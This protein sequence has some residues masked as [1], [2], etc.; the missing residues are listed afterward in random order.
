M[1]VLAQ[2]MGPDEWEFSNKT[3]RRRSVSGRQLA[4]KGMRLAAEV[5]EPRC[6][7]TES[8][9]IDG[10]NLDPTSADQTAADDAA[11]DIATLTA[12]AKT[13]NIA[14]VTTIVVDGSFW[15]DRGLTV[16][17]VDDWVHIV[18]T[19][20]DLDV[21]PPIPVAE[22]AQLILQGRD[23]AGDVLT[24]QVFTRNIVVQ[25]DGGVGAGTDIL[26]LDGLPG[27][28]PLAYPF[29][30][31]FQAAGRLSNPAKPLLV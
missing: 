26:G 11:T 24:L 16:L 9:V 27:R 25:F 31:R 8:V 10:L 18:R 6:L 22:P 30:P 14:G 7:L 12:D 20:T 21:V 17:Q 19:G 4:A 29:D 3:S 5:L 23:N 28:H 13:T 2:V 15:D 1:G